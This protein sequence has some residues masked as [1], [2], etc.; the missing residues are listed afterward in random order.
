MTRAHEDAPT[1]ARKPACQSDGDVGARGTP[2]AQARLPPNRPRPC[3]KKRRIRGGAAS[4]RPRSTSFRRY[5]LRGLLPRSWRN[6]KGRGSLAAGACRRRSLDARTCAAVRNS[7]QATMGAPSI[8]ALLSG[9]RGAL[10][11]SG[12]ASTSRIRPHQFGIADLTAWCGGF[13]GI[14]GG[15]PLMREHFFYR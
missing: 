6:E 5:A 15:E 10:N 1:I 3:R 8:T 14:A 11:G 12:A 4:I 7:V 2:A 13:V 9:Q